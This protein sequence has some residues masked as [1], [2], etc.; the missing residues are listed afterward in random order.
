[1]TMTH[2]GASSTT[3]AIPRRIA[4]G[5]RKDYT[6]RLLPQWPQNAIRRIGVVL[7]A[8][9]S[10]EWLKRSRPGNARSDTCACAGRVAACVIVCRNNEQGSDGE[11]LTWLEHDPEKRA[12]IFRKDHA[13]T[14]T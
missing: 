4:K 6:R 14:I 2:I 13:Q 7:T 11:R 10:T 3:C 9:S 5:T 8:Q 12:A 1:M